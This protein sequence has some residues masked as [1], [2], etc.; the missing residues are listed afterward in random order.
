MVKFVMLCCNFVTHAVFSEVRLINYMRIGCGLVAPLIPE[1]SSNLCHSPQDTKCFQFNLLVGKR[2]VSVASA[3]S[4]LLL[5]LQFCQL[6]NTT[7]P[8]TH[9]RTR[10]MSTKW[11]NEL[12]VP[13]MRWTWPK[14]HYLNSIYLYLNCGGM[15]E[16]WVH[17]YQ[18]QLRPCIL[19]SS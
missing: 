2:V 17:R 11:A 13:T 19:T 7:F 18:H 16:V 3:W 8:T 15:M 5:T 12:N 4:S 14:T 6:L 9:S 10:E 1:G